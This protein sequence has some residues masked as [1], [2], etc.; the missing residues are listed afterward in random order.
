M[1]S[2][3]LILP[4]VVWNVLALSGGMEAFNVS[5]ELRIMDL[6]YRTE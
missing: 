5:K 4:T 2:S 6:Y 1:D 3:T